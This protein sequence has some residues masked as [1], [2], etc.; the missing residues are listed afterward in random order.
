MSWQKIL[1]YLFGDSS[2]VEGFFEAGPGQKSSQS[3]NH[4]KLT[5]RLHNGR[6]LAWSPMAA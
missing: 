1:L 2:T 6:N 3:E 4:Q 5:A